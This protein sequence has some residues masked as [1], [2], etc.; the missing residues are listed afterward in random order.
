MKLKEIEENSQKIKIFYLPSYSQDLNPDEYL[1]NDLKRGLNTK[2][3]PRNIQ[4]LKD[5]T[6]VLII[7]SRYRSIITCHEKLI[8]VKD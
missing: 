1:N 4:H 3:M 6:F 8:L 2:R 5:G 7:N